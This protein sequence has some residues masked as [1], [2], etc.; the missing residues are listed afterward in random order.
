LVESEIKDYRKCSVCGSFKSNLSQNNDIY[1]DKYWSHE[2]GHST[3]EEQKYNVESYQY[4]GISKND[5]VLQYCPG[6]EKVLEIACAP[7]NLLKRLNEKYLHVD[8][9]EVDPRYKH[10]IQKNAGT[11]PNIFFGIFP[12]ITENWQEQYDLIIALDLFEHVEDSIGFV[13][14]CYRLLGKHGRLILMLPIYN[15]EKPCIDMF[16][17]EEHIWIYTREAISK[18]LSK[19]NLIVYDTWRPGH[20]IVIAY[21]N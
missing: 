1:Y 5:K 18:L 19:F 21:K 3:L 7:G 12:E 14:E 10:E 20:D 4:K 8:G 17:P 2:K 6:G 11:L 13:N 9:I 15:D 16:C